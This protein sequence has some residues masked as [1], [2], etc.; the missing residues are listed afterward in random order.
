MVT[1]I[2]WVSAAIRAAA[3]PATP[4]PTTSNRSLCVE[5][6]P[7]ADVAVPNPRP[8]FFAHP[9]FEEEKDDD[10]P[11]DCTRLRQDRSPMV[12]KVLIVIVVY[13]FSLLFSTIAAS[14]LCWGNLVIPFV[15]EEEN[16][17]VPVE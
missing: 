3:L 5:A 6:T 2:L 10:Q 15:P 1:G 8:Q 4:E 12:R 9:L 14:I 11:F 16:N 17:V 7:L 13:C